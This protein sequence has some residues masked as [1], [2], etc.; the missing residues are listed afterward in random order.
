M[1]ASFGSLVIDTDE[2]LDAA[3]VTFDNA[4]AE[5]TD[6][7]KAV[8]RDTQ[9]ANN[10]NETSGYDLAGSFAVKRPAQT[11]VSALEALQD[12]NTRVYAQFTDKQGNAWIA[13]SVL[14]K[15]V[16]TPMRTGFHR[17]D[18]SFEG[19]HPVKASLIGFTAAV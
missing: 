8:S 10:E 14:I 16:D 5:G 12:T 19:F 11:D 3:P 2:T 15:V 7:F 9:N 18:I 13:K 4:L 6:P 1:K 17:L